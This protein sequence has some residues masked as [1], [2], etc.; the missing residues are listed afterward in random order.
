MSAE[1]IEEALAPV[2][3]A[4]ELAIRTK[5]YAEELKRREAPEDMCEQAAEVAFRAFELLRQAVLE[6]DEAVFQSR[7]TQR[8]PG[9]PGL[10]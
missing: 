2:Y 5:A 3:A 9:S 8:P 7:G 6:L 10:N 1:R 4:A